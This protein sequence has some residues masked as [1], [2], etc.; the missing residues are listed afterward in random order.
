[1]TDRHPLDHVEERTALND[2]QAQSDASGIALGGLDSRVT[3]LEGA[4]SSS[5]TLYTPAL[6]ASSV[7]PNLGST[8]TAEG[9]Y[10]R[11][12]E[13]VVMEFAFFFDGA[14]I[15]QGTGTYLIS[16]PPIQIATPF[17]GQPYLLGEV[18]VTDSGVGSRTFI[19]SRASST[20]VQLHQINT[21]AF[22]AS[23]AITNATIGLTFAAGDRV[24]GVILYT[25]VA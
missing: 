1:M 24:T 10:Y 19:P 5:P 15:A 20:L 23:G 9:R 11:T 25:A 16:A 7:N 21:T 22:G 4:V 17:T 8:G 18:I 3:A 12:G 6:T 13:L 14:G 2:L